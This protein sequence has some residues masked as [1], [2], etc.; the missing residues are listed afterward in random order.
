MRL[1]LFIPAVLFVHLLWAQPERWQ[2]GV[3]YEMD[4]DMD[5][6]THRFSGTQRLT[7]FNH[8]PDSLDRI[9][10]HLYLNA[11][12]PGS[13]MDL[14]SRTISD[15]D[16]R[17]ADR[18]LDLKPEE[19]GYQRVLSLLHNGAPAEYAVEGTILEV[20]LPRPV[21]P[22]D[23]AVFEMTFE[24]QVPV[25]IR[26]NGR[27]SKEGVAY[28]M[29]Q[30]YPKICHYDYQ[31]WHA[32][33]YI[34]REFYGH[35]GD[36]D[37]VIRIDSS[38]VIGATGYLQ[39][40]REIGH[41]YPRDGG[42]VQRPAGEKLVWR[43]HAPKVNDFVWAADPD[44]LHTTYTRTDGIE[45][46][47]FYQK[48]CPNLEEWLRLPVF[49]DTAITYLNNR[50][51]QYPYQQYSFI[52]G[53]DGGMEYPM[54]TLITGN[55]SLGSLV[56][57]SVHELVH[58]WYPMILGTNEALYAWMDEGF[59]TYFSNEVMN[60]IR[61]RGML[62]GQKEREN[63]QGPIYAGYVNLV[64]SG[65]EEPMS[66][67]A[68]HF[69]T[70]YAYGQASYDKG[71]VFLHQL[72]Y[73]IGK[74][75]FDRGMLDYFETWKFKHPNVN[76][77]IRVMEKMSGMELD[78]YREYFVNTTFWPDYAIYSV[79]SAPQNSS[80]VV[81]GR[82]GAMPMPVDV[83]VVTMEGQTHHYTIP[84]D[85]MRGAK[86]SEE[87]TNYTVAPDWIWVSPNYELIIG[88]PPGKIRSI[89]I[90]PSLRLADVDRSNN[91]REAPWN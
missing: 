91:R 44:F 80:K 86:T 1:F 40:P 33:P 28:S 66:T 64:Q 65:Q 60:H 14:R 15:P 71:A 73:I 77:F 50:C 78:W 56:G 63:P 32:N 88:I 59:S 17:V 18:I 4:I 46:H 48:D 82:I 52:Q 53:G 29:A 72:S 13:A 16:Y 54:A 31:G 62:P 47:C 23:S 20:K 89:E 75:K 42:P 25:Q 67:H 10:Y 51:G 90:D 79:A 83:R 69:Q 27:D 6:K 26:R 12:Q 35:F 81:L 84:L 9:F 76:D 68:D 55:R 7:Y 34:A 37:V 39:N 11:F 8:S 58:A 2:Q 49:M 3:R 36:Y 45:I 70:N 74:E 30:W 24:S 21:M 85:I 38:Y 22:G 57:V 87:G 41:G 61:M 19:Q 43:F 5:V